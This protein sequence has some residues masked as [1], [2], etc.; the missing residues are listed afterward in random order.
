MLPAGTP[1]GICHA[2][3]V[4]H[5]Q[6]LGSRCGSSPLS[7]TGGDSLWGLSPAQVDGRVGERGTPWT[8]ATKR[9]QC[10]ATA[11]RFEGQRVAHLA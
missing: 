6:R 1:D 3:A 9:A 4:P 10:I 2:W 8:Q 5:P 11:L 7:A